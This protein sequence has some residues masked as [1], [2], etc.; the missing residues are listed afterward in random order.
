MVTSAPTSVPPPRRGRGKNFHF[1]RTRTLPHDELPHDETDCRSSTRLAILPF[2][3]VVSVRLLRCV[4]HP[5]IVLFLR[6]SRVEQ[7]LRMRET[8][9]RIPHPRQHS[10]Q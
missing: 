7:F 6:R 2:E 5:T 1:N 3:H 9:L 8:G 10:R 4:P